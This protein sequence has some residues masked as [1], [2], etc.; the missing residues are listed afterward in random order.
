MGVFAIAL[1]QLLNFPFTAL[2]LQ[3]HQSNGLQIDRSALLAFKKGILADPQNMLSNWIENIHVCK[4][5]GIICSQNGER[6]TMLY[7]GSSF[8]QGTI[9]PFLS[10]LSCLEQLDLSENFLQ[11]PIPSELGNLESLTEFSLKGNLMQHEIPES[12]GKLKKL[13]YINLSGNQLQGQLPPSLFYNCT[14]FQYI[15]LS[16]NSFTGFI[17]SEIGNHLP[18]LSDLYLYLNNLVGSIPVSLSNASQLMNLDLESNFLT[19]RLPSEVVMHMHQLRTLHLSYNKLSSPDGNTNLTPFFNSISNLTHL[20]EL[21]LSGNNLGGELP[22]V[23]GLMHVNLS[24]LHLENNLIQGAIPSNIAYLS[25]LTLLNLS[26]NLLNGSIPSEISHLPK[27]ERLCLSNNSLEGEI[28]AS[29]GT[30]SHLGLLD[31]SRNKLSGCIPTTLENLTQLR[32]LI[33]NNNMLSGT[34]PPN[35][36]KCPSLETLDLAHNKVTGVIPAEVAGLRDMTI[37]FNLSNNFLGGMVPLELSKMDKIRAIDLSSNNFTGEI[38]ANLDDCLAVEL[39]NL[40][41]NSLQ[42]PVPK[43]MGNLLSIKSLDLS[44]NHL[45]SEIPAFLQNSNTLTE[46]NLSYNNF[47]GSIPRGGIFDSLTFDSFRGN[48]N[49]I[50]SSFGAPSS[51]SKQRT[52]RHSPKFTGILVSIVSASVFLLTI[53]CMVGVKKLRRSAIHRDKGILGKYSPALISSYPRIT[54]R[55]LEEA[56][57]GFEQS[58]LIGLGSFGHVYR[59]V[60]RDGSVVAVKVLQLQARN[61]TK[62]F[63]RECQILKRIRH[64]NLMRIVTACSLPDFKALVLPFMANG[65]LESH[66][67]PQAQ[68]SSNSSLTLIER[69]NI[70]SDV[71]EGLAYL[72]HHSPIQVIHCDLKPSNILLNDDMNAL[73]TDFG[74]ARLVMTAEQGNMTV[75]NTTISTANLLCGS[76]GYIA[77]EYGMGRNASTKGD[78]YSFGILVLEIVT[79]KRPTDDMFVGGLSL[80]KW[81]KSHYHGR[82]EKVINYSLMRAL[83]DQSPEVRNMSEVA[84]SELI[85]LGLLCTQEAP[86]TR[87]TMLDAADDLDRLKRYLTGDITATFASSLGIS[88]STITRGDFE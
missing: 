32:R 15:D 31:L 42:G 83:W 74:I 88:S 43:S 30:L 53:C 60:L 80:P 56:T 9:S 44:Y 3:E 63:N 4:W 29:L 24:E 36:G 23:I 26:S 41:H 85:E 17:P 82:L 37:Y 35:L 11:G 25:N 8:L 46:L 12:L 34:I 39:I 5:N 75:E 52:R 20:R 1:I 22:S 81:V 33:L 79:G 16:S 48:P 49:L 57:E 38:P 50:D 45:S 84:I 55:E 58:R 40:S 13:L 14:A 73:V 69:V 47:S 6:V 65:S 78:V 62:S 86:S 59:G 28:P 51:H 7:L 70:L 67:Y 71:A 77:P 18:N 72:H 54:Y 64:R 10:N 27:L 19:G 87:P 76:I 61:S 68:S 66:L 2:P 21:E